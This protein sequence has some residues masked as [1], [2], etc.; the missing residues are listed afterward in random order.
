M[1]LG[2]LSF[3]ELGTV[4]PSSGAEYAFFRAAFT[5]CHSF[6][7]PLPGFVYIWVIVFLVRPAEV[8]IL[9]LTF[10]EYTYTPIVHYFSLEISPLMESVLKKLIALL[11]VG[12]I[13]IIQ[14]KIY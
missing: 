14:I 9:V 10:S 5:D 11:A 7:G 4:V 1:F 12:I 6:F 3:A 2:A 8:A 13:I